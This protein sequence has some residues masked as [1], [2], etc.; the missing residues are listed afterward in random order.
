M[1]VPYLYVA[2]AVI[3]IQMICLIWLFI[4]Q[5][6]PVMPVPSYI[7]GILLGFILGILSKSIWIDD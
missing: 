4:Y 2:I 5:P 7:I 1:R 6:D 3:V